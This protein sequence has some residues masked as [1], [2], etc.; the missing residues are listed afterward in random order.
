MRNIIQ[1]EKTTWIDITKPTKQDVEYL[2]N[3]YRFH[4]MVLDQLIPRVYHPRLETKPDYLFIIINYPQYHETDKEV[5]PR[6]LDIILTKNTIITNHFRPFFVLENLFKT[7]QRPEIE[8]EK[9][10][11]KGPGFVLFSILDTFWR[12]SLLKLNKLSD[13]IDK[14][15]KRIFKGV[16]KE[17]VIEISHI[18]TDIMD[19]WRIIDPQFE[20]MK[21][22][23][24]EG[25][26]FFGEEFSFHF[27]D[28]LQTYER[29]WQALKAH[30]ETILA[31]E[32][33]NRSLLTIKTN[34]I[35]KILTIFS[36]ILM[37]PTLLAS[38]WGMN[39]K[40]PFGQHQSGFWIVGAIMAIVL[41]TMFIYFRKKKWL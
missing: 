40:L 15:E 38:I 27:S 35:I 33:T 25:P 5:S 23:E 10:L 3:Q 32:D 20:I 30:K 28:M 22:L 2:K 24:K 14:I 39:V 1:N 36:L 13:E 18:K 17:M 11:D 16:E 21:S 8:G 19:F 29:V 7:C 26:K 6:E 37:P 41:V 4:P 34:E 9:Y 12:D 31:L